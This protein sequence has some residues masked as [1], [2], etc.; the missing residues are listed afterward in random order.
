M[1]AFASIQL[2]A[3]QVRWVLSGPAGLHLD[4]VVAGLIGAGVS[5]EPISA[6][7][8]YRLRGPTEMLDVLGDEL[9]KVERFALRREAPPTDTIAMQSTLAPSHAAR[10]SVTVH[11]DPGREAASFVARAVDRG[12]AVESVGVGRWSVTARTAALVDWL[13]AVYV[14]PVDEVLTLFDWDAASVA[15]EDA[16]SP[17]VSITLPPL[18]VAVSLPVRKTISTFKH[19]ADGNVTQAL[20]IETDVPNE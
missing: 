14:K 16:A 11:G 17:A 13:A 5:V 15:A 18:Q 9:G 6:G 3:A 8:C 20:Q 19:D 10:R 1:S 12:M 2:P 7:T 4:A